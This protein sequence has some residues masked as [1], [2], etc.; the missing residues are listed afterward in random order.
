MNTGEHKQTHYRM[1]T[2]INERTQ[3]LFTFVHITKR[4]KFLVHVVRSFIKRTNTNKFSAEQF[5]NCSLNV[6]F[7]CSPT[8]DP[9][10]YACEIIYLSFCFTTI[11]MDFVVESPHCE[12]KVCGTSR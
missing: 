1:F 2:N 4:T 6:W 11:Q 7:I 8:Y 12:D 10:T 9:M 5:T 3:P